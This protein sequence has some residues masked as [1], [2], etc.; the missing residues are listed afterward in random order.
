MPNRKVK[1]ERSIAQSQITLALHEIPC[2]C[3]IGILP[4][5]RLNE[6]P[7]FISARFWGDFNTVASSG[8]LSDGVDYSILQ[9]D[10]QQI[11][12]LARFRLIETASL[13]LCQ[14]SLWRYPAIK[15]VEI[16]IKKPQALLGQGIPEINCVLK[17][18]KR[19]KTHFVNTPDIDIFS[20]EISLKHSP[21][22][23]ALK[24]VDSVIVFVT[25]PER[26]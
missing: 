6:Q 14:W 17:Q 3:H 1:K 11:L 9:Q 15:K 5:E 19:K 16:S 20:K 26:E 24:L 22:M 13:A 10:F 25:L 12:K 23:F 7:V 8:K 18:S 21:K 4:L 2:L